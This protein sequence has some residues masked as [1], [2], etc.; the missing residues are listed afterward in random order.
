MSAS[1]SARSTRASARPARPS[2][3]SAA[4]ATSRPAPPPPHCPYCAHAERFPVPET[5]LSAEAQFKL[6]EWLGER[7]RS[8]QVKGQPRFFTYNGD[9]A[10]IWGEHAQHRCSGTTLHEAWV[11]S[12]TRSLGIE[13]ERAARLL[14]LEWM[15]Q[16][17]TIDGKTRAEWKQALTGSLRRI[18]QLYQEIRRRRRSE[19]S[20]LAVLRAVVDTLP[21]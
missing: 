12:I 21:K 6:G 20:A 1:R 2:A 17:K 5:L 9:S 3:R 19:A 18:A 15:E 8:W 13:L 16:D 10:P 11:R 14:T 7:A 4:R